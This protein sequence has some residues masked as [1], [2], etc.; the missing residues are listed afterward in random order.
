MKARPLSSEHYRL[1]HYNLLMSLLSTHELNESLE[2]NHLTRLLFP[3]YFIIIFYPKYFLL[4]LLK[5]LFIKRILN[6]V[7]VII[8]YFI[9]HWN[10]QLHFGNC[11]NLFRS[12]L[13]VSFI[14]CFLFLC[15][16]NMI[17][18]QKF[19]VN[20]LPPNSG[21]KFLHTLF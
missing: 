18:N 7:S 9:C 17:T 2:P 14:K 10:G 20:I 1:W 11:K 19:G 4:R 15:Y 6:F 12:S 16:S 8:S 21:Y 5:F 3:C 13:S